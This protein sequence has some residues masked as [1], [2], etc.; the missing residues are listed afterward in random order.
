[1]AAAGK[2]K[3]LFAER[4]SRVTKRGWDLGPSEGLAADGSVFPP[5]GPRA[6]GQLGAG[7]QKVL[8]GREGWRGSGGAV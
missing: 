6:Y 1:M 7:V 8:Q 4:C 2:R 3:E 5:A